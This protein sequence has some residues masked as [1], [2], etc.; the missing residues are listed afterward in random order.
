MP[1]DKL[2]DYS[3][4]NA[5]NQDVGGV[6]TDEGMLPSAVNNAIREVMTHLKNFASG[7]DGIDVLS[8]ADDDAS[9]A[10]KIQAPASVTADTTLT[11]PDGDGSDGQALVTDGSGTLSWADLHSARNLIIN[12]GYTVFQRSTSATGVT[13]DTYAAPDRWKTRVIDTSEFTISQSTDVPS[14]QG[15]TYSCKWACTTANASP[16]ATAFIDHEQRIEAQDLQ[17]LEYGT[18]SAKKLTVSF[19]VKSS[20]TG[21]HTYGLYQ[22]DGTR[23]NMT[24]YNIT[25]ANTWQKVTH[26]FDGDTAGT[27]N[28]DTGEGLRLWFILGAGSNFSSGTQQSGWAAYLQ[29]QV[30][31]TNS[32]NLADSTSNEWYITGVQL[33]VGDV[34]LPFIHESYGETLA[35]CQRYYQRIVAVNTASGFAVGTS[36]NNT[37]H[38]F[39]YHHPVTMRAN[40]S[41]GKSALADLLLVGT[42]SSVT[43]TSFARQGGSPEVSEFLCNSTAHGAAGNGIWVR[44]KVADKYVDWSAEL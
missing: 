28:A 23:S 19:W 17:H 9:A 44:I 10:M 2:T 3:A 35:K 7:T 42:G 13:T 43:P 25:T 15:F 37:T 18:S 21:V 40:P 5:S 36:F 33:T 16:A 1:K 20:K 26:T 41:I 6:N 38:Y 12:G 32:V 11:L 24:S 29:S 8:L 4:T 30:L 39:V 34:D 31:A 27:I 14:G 22:A